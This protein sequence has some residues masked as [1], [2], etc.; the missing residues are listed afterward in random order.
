MQQRKLPENHGL[1]GREL[2]KTDIV[3]KCSNQAESAKAK[4]GTKNPNQEP[5]RCQ[6]N[7][8]QKQN[9]NIH[10]A[11]KLSYF[12]PRKLTTMALPS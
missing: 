10:E 8:Q 11:T 12:R 6:R 7:M 2:A 4:M 9:M 5:W 1:P 3:E